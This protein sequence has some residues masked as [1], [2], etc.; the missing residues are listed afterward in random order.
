MTKHA[1]TPEEKDSAAN[2]AR[3]NDKDIPTSGISSIHEPSILKPPKAK[4]TESD[5]RNKNGGWRWWAK[6]AVECFGLAVAAC[7]AWLTYE[8]LVEIRK[9]TP[10]VVEA[11][12]IANRNFEVSQRAYLSFGTPDS[13]SGRTLRIPI[14]NFGHVAVDSILAVFSYLIIQINSDAIPQYETST[15]YVHPIRPGS[16]SDF[17]LYVNLPRLPPRAVQAI[18]SGKEKVA[19][20]GR[21]IYDT[22]FFKMDTL[23]I[24]VYY[25]HV[26]KRWVRSGEGARIDLETQ[27]QKK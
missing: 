8:N 14:E 2:N 5:N 9:Q 11:T 19:V 6:F 18:E 21:I 3:H 1:E 16:G 25:N 17:A 7:L 10:S 24:L 20:S 26:M 22:G 13:G 15:V 23:V 27:A 4:D 12:G